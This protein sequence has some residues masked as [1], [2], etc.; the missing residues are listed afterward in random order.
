MTGSSGLFGLSGFSG[1]WLEY[2]II[3][4]EDLRLTEKFSQKGIGALGFEL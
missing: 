4:S 1:Y 3:F 2:G